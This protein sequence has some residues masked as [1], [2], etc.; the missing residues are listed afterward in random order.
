MH[1]AAAQPTLL[2]ESARPA[3]RHIRLLIAVLVTAIMILLAG[4]TTVWIV[5]SRQEILRDADTGLRH[6]AHLL[7]EA[8]A[9][10]FITVDK[11][12]LAS[13]EVAA[14]QGRSAGLLTFLRRQLTEAPAARALLVIGPDGIS[15]VATNLPDP[16]RPVDLSDRPYFRHHLDGSAPALYVSGVIQS[17]ND[18]RWIMVLS[19]R[20]ETPDGA[21]AGVVAATIN[22]EQLAS[23][24]RAAARNTRDSALLVTPD[25]AILARTPDH[26]RY[27]GKSLAGIAAFE[28]T[29]TEANGGGEVAASPLDGQRRLY[30]FHKA[31]SHP[32]I[33]VTSHEQDA[34]LTD[35]RRHSLLLAAAAILVGL[36]IGTLA[37][38]LVRQLERMRDTLEELAR[39]RRA[40][41]AANR[42]KSAFLAN[43]SHELRTPLNAIIGFSDALMEGIPG[44][45]CQTRCQDYLGHVQTSG[46]HLLTLIND[47][48][49]LSKIEA[50]RLEVA[51]VPTVV[52][53]LVGECVGIIRT[54][55]EA[56]DISITTAGLGRDLVAMVDPRR[57]RQILLNLLSNAV[58][59]TPQGGRVILEVE[60]D[61]G[62]LSLTVNDT[63]I[64]MAPEEIAVALT[65][66]GQNPSE[67]AKAEAGTG[68][69]LPL[70]KRLVELHGGSLSIASIPG[71][72]T[73]VTVH[74]PLPPAAP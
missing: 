34:L 64:G 40:A 19:R 6:T 39:S 3:S 4:G 15:R 58:K 12:L 22:L 73:T 8:A 37:L 20:I 43:M 46:R 59:F 28:R 66:F 33:A 25:G 50:D 13:A 24:L 55:A 69:G 38:I 70:S 72:G 5:V 71:R 48:L 53:G 30:A 16:R 62:Q 63:G 32:V 23:I 27:V 45:S 44:H 17:R 35:W 52:A 47:I 65:P 42:A 21:F 31:T 54:Q 36:V 60:H 29:R 67:L 57:L 49:D 18:G 41:D 1:P 9:S 11:V 61:S 7:A 56:K 68:L 2:P 10:N 51:P 26:E 14:L 74:I